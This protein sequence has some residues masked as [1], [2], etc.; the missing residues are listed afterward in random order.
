MLT[1]ADRTR[2]RQSGRHNFQQCAVG[3]EA[4]DKTSATGPDFRQGAISDAVSWMTGGLTSESREAMESHEIV[5]KQVVAL[6]DKGSI[7]EY[8][9]ERAER[10]LNAIQRWV[11]RTLPSYEGYED[12]TAL[13]KTFQRRVSEIERLVA[14]APTIIAGD[15]DSSSDSD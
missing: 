4:G 1:E 7:E 13:L 3:S 6:A 14:P 9:R 8:D 11:A 2:L 12:A 10:A 15:S 5:L